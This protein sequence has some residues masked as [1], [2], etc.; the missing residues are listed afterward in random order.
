MGRRGRES[1]SNRR[2]ALEPAPAASRRTV[3]RLEDPLGSVDRAAAAFG[4]L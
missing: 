1:V 3:P 2:R 4:A